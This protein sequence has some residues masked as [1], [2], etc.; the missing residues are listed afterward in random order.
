MAEA[1]RRVVSFAAG[2]PDFDT[3]Q[4]VCEAAERAIRDGRTRYTPSAGTTELREAV[5][6]KFVRENGLAATPAT[7]MATCGAKQAL[8]NAMSVLLD[9]G[10]EVVVPAPCWPTYLDQAEL[11]GARAVPVPCRADDGYPLDLGA[12]EDAVGPRTRAIVLNSPCNPTGAA[13][14]DDEIATVG[15]IADR[16]GLWIVSDEI[17]ERIRYGSP[18]VSAALLCD[19]ERTVTVSG[20]SKSFAMT[21]WRIG[22]V[23]APKAVLD[24]MVCVQDQ[25]TSNPTS[26]AQAGAV[27][28]LSLPPE[29]VAA[30]TDR[31]RARRDLIVELLANRLGSEV[32]PPQGA[33][34][35]LLDVRRWAGEGGDK[36]LADRVLER[37]GVATVPG[38]FFL[39]PGTIR[40]SY[41]ASEEDIDEGTARLAEELTGVK[42]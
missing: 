14:S 1:G 29:A 20:C 22:F 8:Y 28:A 19:P 34:Y 33:F 15:R 5:A 4:A 18:H 16:H 6:A 21:G 23:H 38:S 41:A 39:A 42:A 13:Y 7:V 36:A 37:A 12:I 24:A 11:V 35:V 25:V 17:Y 9:P 3:P 10:D 31:F 27:A 32:R 26:F 2:E 30:M 40:L